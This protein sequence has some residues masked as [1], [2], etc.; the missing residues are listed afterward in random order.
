MNLVFTH[1]Y[2]YRLILYTLILTKD[3]L[4]II[5]IPLMG[6][7]VIAIPIIPFLFC[8]LLHFLL[9]PIFLPFLG[10]QLL[11]I[12]LPDLFDVV[13]HLWFGMF[14]GFSLDY[15]LIDALQLISKVQVLVTFLI[16]WKVLVFSSLS[17]F[18]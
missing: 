16:L 12:P 8:F 11:A 4:L 3:Y 2:I 10:S 13:D 14:V 17:P 5:T 6:L 15:G 7:P 1:I 18:I 9:L